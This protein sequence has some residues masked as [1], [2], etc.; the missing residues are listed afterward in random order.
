M[1]LN[2]ESLVE[3]QVKRELENMDL[4]EIVENEVRRVVSNGIGKEIVSKVSLLADQMIAEECRKELDGEVETDDGWGH[5]KTY[6]SFEELFRET[7]KNRM[8]SSYDVKREIEKLVKERVE[9]LIKQDYNK[10]LE[11]IVDELS[12]S[13]LVKNDNRN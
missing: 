6:S 13:K 7:F 4:R 11:K 3:A 8:N 9:S 10:V 12:K 5:R 2:I 1:D